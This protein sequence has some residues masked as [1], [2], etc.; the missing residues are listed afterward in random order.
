MHWTVVCTVDGSLC[1]WQV[2]PEKTLGSLSSDLLCWTIV[3]IVVVASTFLSIA[4]FLLPSSL[5][6]ALLTERLTRLLLLL[7]SL[8]D[9]FVDGKLVPRYLWTIHL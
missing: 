4:L 1:F 5:W 3:E 9:L 6:V 7:S 8:N 2:V